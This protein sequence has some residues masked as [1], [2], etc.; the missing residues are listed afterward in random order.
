MAW[1]GPSSRYPVWCGTTGTGSATAQQVNCTTDGAKAGD[2][3]KEASLGMLAARPQFAQM[4]MPAKPGAASEAKPVSDAPAMPA[5]PVHYTKFTDQRE[6]GY[7]LMDKY[8]IRTA[9]E[10]SSCEVCHR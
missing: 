8:H 1:Q 2:S 5:L 3:S 10:L 9:N 6:L 4:E 7:Y